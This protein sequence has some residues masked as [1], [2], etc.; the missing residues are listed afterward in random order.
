[1]FR[2]ILGE[3]GVV[4][5][6]D[7]LV[8]H[9][10]AWD[11]KFK[12]NSGLMLR[13]E[14]SEQVSQCL[15][16]CNDRM[17]A[18]VPQAGNTGLVGGSVPVHDEVILS[19]SRMNKILDFDESYGIIS[20]EAGVILRNLQNHAEERGYE[21]PLDLGAK[22]S[23]QIGGNLANNAGGLKVIRQNSLHAN[24]IGLKAVLPNGTILDNMTTL[25]KDNTGY[26][27]KHL[28]IG[29]EGTLGLITECAILCPPHATKKNLALVSLN[30]FEAVL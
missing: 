9:N 7:D 2:D 23:C 6:Q 16:H 30:S 20:S 15:K 11:K 1:M 25:R 19:T 17:L 12:G 13:P 29:S 22:D 24:T 21:V 14:T 8:P 18:V 5:D 28:F 26:D 27:L 10:T 4:T 3:S